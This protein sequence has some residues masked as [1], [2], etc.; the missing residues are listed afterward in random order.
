MDPAIQSM[1]DNLP[2]NTGKSLDE[3]FVVLDAAG[4]EKH[5]EMMSL[6]KSEHGVTHGYANGIVLQYRAR[7]TSSSDDDLVEAQ[8][9]G[10]KSAL[11]PIYEAL[12]SFAVGLGP[13]VEVAPKKA[14]V[15][16]RR[17]KQ[18]ALVEPASAK[19]V[20]LGLNLRGVEPVGRLE[21]YSGMCTH[22]VSLTSVDEVDDE[23]RGWL[24]QAY[25]LA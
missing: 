5:G 4:L 12:R 22:R 24:A 7:G 11:R 6:L 9:S 17:S 1:I 14:S 16:L 3:W 10:A 21:A 2:T 15:S 18:F 20:Q 19:R 8:Y 23:V 25:A 13:D